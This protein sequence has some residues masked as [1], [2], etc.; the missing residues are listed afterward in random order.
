[1]TTNVFFLLAAAEPAVD[2]NPWAGALV[3]LLMGIALGLIIGLVVK[4]FGAKVDPRQ[5]EAEGLLPGANCGGCGFA[6]CADFARALVEG[7]A[8]PSQCPVCGPE[9]LEKICGVLGLANAG[10]EKEVAIVLCGGDNTKAI[11]NGLY[12]GVNDCKDAVLVAGG[13]KG[14]SY[15]CLGLGS[16]ARACPFGA[17]EITGDGIAVIHPEI[18]VGCKK[19]VVTCPRN[20]IKMIPA[21]V[22]VHILCNNPEKGAAKMKVCKTSCIGCRKCWKTC[23]DQTQITFNKFL[24]QINYDNPPSVDI[25]DV[26]PTKCIHPTL[27]TEKTP[28]TEDSQKG[29]DNA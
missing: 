29:D 20:L 1:M 22:P 9:E 28:K 18:C 16:C 6:G 3:L 25:V 15:G 4:F 21:K 10:K 12:N 23:E 17:I 26:C 5:E 19:C 2:K 24:A 13:P 14:C 7:E 27:G 8:E 11:Q